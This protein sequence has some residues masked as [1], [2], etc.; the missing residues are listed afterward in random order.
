MEIQKFKEISAS[1]YRNIQSLTPD[2]IVV[3][4]EILN[5]KTIKYGRICTFSVE[6]SS[7]IIMLTL[8]QNCLILIKFLIENGI[9]LP[10]ELLNEVSNLLLEDRG[11]ET[12]GAVMYDITNNLNAQMEIERISKQI[13]KSIIDIIYATTYTNDKIVSFLENR[14]MPDDLSINLTQLINC[15]Y[16]SFELI[17]LN[18]LLVGPVLLSV[19]ESYHDKLRPVVKDKII[20]GLSKQMESADKKVIYRIFH[21]MNNKKNNDL[22]RAINF[23]QSGECLGCISS[24]ICDEESAEIAYEKLSPFFSE[25]EVALD[26]LINESNVCKKKLQKEDEELIE[27]GLECVNKLIKYSLVRFYK[28]LGSLQRLLKIPVDKKIKGNIYEILSLYVSDR[29]VFI[30]KVMDCREEVENEIREK[31]FFL[32]PRFIRFLNAYRRRE[33]VE[34]ELVMEGKSLGSPYIRRGDGGKNDSEEEYLVYGLK[35]E[36]PDCVIECIDGNISEYTIEMNAAHIRNTMVKD[37]R[38][39]KKLFNHQI[40][41][42]KVLRSVSIINMILRMPNIDFFKYAELFDDFTMYLNGDVLERIGDNLEEGIAWLTKNYSTNVG[43]WILKNSGYFNDL[44]VENESLQQKL[45]PIYEKIFD[46]NVG[47]VKIVVTNGEQLPDNTFVVSDKES[48]VCEEFFKVFAKQMI[49]EKFQGDGECEKF[50][51]KKKYI[52]KGFVLYLKA[53]VVCGFDITGDLD[54]MKANLLD[55]SEILGYLSIVVPQ[56]YNMA[57]Y[58]DN[59]ECGNNILL[60]FRNK[61]S[62]HFLKHFSSASDF[63]K[64]VLFFSIK[65]VNKEIDSLIKNEIMKNIGAKNNFYL[66]MCIVHLFKCSNLDKILKILE[67]KFD[68]KKLLFKLNIHNISNGGKYCS[69]ILINQVN[70]SLRVKAIFFLYHYN[71]WD[72]DYLYELIDKLDS[73]GVDDLKYLKKNYLLFSDYNSYKTLVD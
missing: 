48:T 43:R 32:L 42:K 11:K 53:K 60:N 10:N 3:L 34:E 39:G 38:V 1:V 65:E 29:N 58:L 13:F 28:F 62:S 8:K 40:T 5:L 37:T 45:L 51:L 44:L 72:K 20:D 25:L 47:H 61:D 52:N 21:M 14:C 24:L 54:F 18:K 15:E 23:E 19:I 68:D 31:S 46:D 63:E 7:I 67:K 33:E 17:V 71:L 2:G 27:K 36:D 50:L 30:E 12:N 26:V 49:Y 66:R 55:T 41:K 56:K 64:F 70:S 69:K 4:K 6:D 59:K 35:S 9:Q 57:N 22:L 73:E 16:K